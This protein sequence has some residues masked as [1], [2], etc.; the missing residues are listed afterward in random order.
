L[1]ESLA[2][3]LTARNLQYGEG[4]WPRSSGTT[5]HRG[6]GRLP[7]S[8]RRK[9]QTD[10]ESALAQYEGMSP[11][12]FWSLANTVDDDHNE[13]LV[14]WQSGESQWGDESGNGSGNANSTGDQTESTFTAPDSSTAPEN[15]TAPED[16]TAPDTPPFTLEG[17]ELVAPPSAVPTI[18]L[19]DQLSAFQDMNRFGQPF[20]FRGVNMFDRMTANNELGEAILARWTGGPSQPTMMF[21]T[22]SPIREDRQDVSP[23]QPEQFGDDSFGCNDHGQ[24]EGTTSDGFPFHPQQVGDI[25]GCKYHEQ[26]QAANPGGLNFNRSV[27]PAEGQEDF[28]SGFEAQF[29]D[30]DQE[31]L[32]IQI[33]DA[34]PLIAPNTNWDAMDMVPDLM[35]DRRPSLLSTEPSSSLVTPLN[36]AVL[37]YSQP[38][39]DMDNDSGIFIAHPETAMDVDLS[40]IGQ[41]ESGGQEH[42]EA[43]LDQLERLEDPNSSLL[44]HLDKPETS[45]RAFDNC[46]GVDLQRQ[47]VDGVDAETQPMPI[48][49]GP[50]G[51]DN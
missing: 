9:R 17:N 10:F 11:E 26:P 22:A 46:L 7:T 8:A 43:L 34:S 31:M 49:G 32:E 36:S 4:R 25:F 37:P 35:L 18:N 2:R 45:G 24:P 42:W 3:V 39:H 40:F 41:N 47:A 51:V 28:F 23:V 50:A 38:D 12:T 29:N 15:F 21:D 19:F 44:G 1:A 16:F 30:N 13:E 27:S 33:G 20:G 6:R 5:A 48:V 14:E